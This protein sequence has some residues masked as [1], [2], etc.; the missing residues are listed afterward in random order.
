MQVQHFRSGPLV[1]GIVGT[2]SAVGLV[3]LG[4][5]FMLTSEVCSYSYYSGTYCSGNDLFIPGVVVLGLGVTLGIIAPITGFG[6]MGR[7]RVELV[8]GN[9]SSRPSSLRF[10][11]VSGG[12]LP[13]GGAMLGAGFVF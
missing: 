4:L 8:T 11:G 1:W 7:N 2:A 9:Y 5:E 3:S 10:A 13:H 6:S 12:P